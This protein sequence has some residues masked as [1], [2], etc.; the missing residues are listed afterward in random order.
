MSRLEWLN[1]ESEED[2]KFKLE[3]KRVMLSLAHLTPSEKLSVKDIVRALMKQEYTYFEAFYCALSSISV[4]RFQDSFG[5]AL[6]K[7]GGYSEGD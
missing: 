5:V 3:A 2:V 1:K 7:S 6:K 4:R